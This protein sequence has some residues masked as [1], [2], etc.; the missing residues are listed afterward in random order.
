MG[1]PDRDSSV[2]GPGARKC[3]RV[4]SIQEEAGVQLGILDLDGAR[5]QLVAHNHPITI[6]VEEEPDMHLGRPVHGRNGNI[7]CDRLRRLR[8]GQHVR[9]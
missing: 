1:S 2:Q 8:D 6:R 9:V 4:G 3:G 7:T 5:S